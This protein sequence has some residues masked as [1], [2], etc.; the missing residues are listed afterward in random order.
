MRD[1][2]QAP[3]QPVRS[4]LACALEQ[5]DRCEN[6][7]REIRSHIHGDHHTAPTGASGVVNKSHPS[8]S[9]GANE[10]ANRTAVLGDTLSEIASSF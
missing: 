7:V 8:A 4:A 5:L 6:L 9:S 10:I 2:P 1:T 3:A